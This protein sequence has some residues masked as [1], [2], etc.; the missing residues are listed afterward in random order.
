MVEELFLPGAFTTYPLE[1]ATIATLAALGLI[2]LIWMVGKALARDD[3][4][5]FARGE[6]Y[7]AAISVVIIGSIAVLLAWLGGVTFVIVTNVLE[8]TEFTCDGGLCKFKEYRGSTKAWPLALTV[9]EK[10]ATCT[11]NCHIA[12]ARSRIQSMKDLVLFFLIDKLAAYSTFETLS[13]VSVSP[14]MMRVAG[15]TPFAGIGIL[16]RAFE[17]MEGVLHGILLHLQFH[18]VFL[19]LLP[20]LFSLFLTAGIVLRA[21]PFTR[22]LGGLFIAISFSLYFVYPL[23][24]IVRAA[25]VQPKGEPFPIEFEG[26]G[27][28]AGLAT[29]EEVLGHF[30]GLRGIISRIES[31]AFSP[32]TPGGLIDSTALFIVWLTAQEIILIYAVVLTVREVSPFF[33]GDVEIAG[34]SKLL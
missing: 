13:S 4:I 30:K 34:L 33:G 16:V 17:N 31:A 3:I 20:T 28:Y 5:A 1:L 11:K 2:A 24:I 23:L 12:V 6:L 26:L 7:Q 8:G 15:I 22:R 10:V 25:I 19:A 18:N 29:E 9:E 32:I 14:P 27:E 21:L